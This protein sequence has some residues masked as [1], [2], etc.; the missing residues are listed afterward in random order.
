MLLID[1]NQTPLTKNMSAVS[2]IRCGRPVYIHSHTISKL[3]ENGPFP[4]FDYLLHSGSALTRR[5][6]RFPQQAW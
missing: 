6:N 4:P 2:R 3:L 1:T 5:A